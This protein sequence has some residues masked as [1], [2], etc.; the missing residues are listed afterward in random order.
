MA[1]NFL[2]HHKHGGAESHNSW[3]AD[4]TTGLAFGIEIENSLSAI[5][6]HSGKENTEISVWNWIHSGT[7]YYSSIVVTDYWL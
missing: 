3:S 1:A 2:R 4:N 5:T 7:E 6:K